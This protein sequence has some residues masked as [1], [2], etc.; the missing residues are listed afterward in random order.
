[1]VKSENLFLWPKDEGGFALFDALVDKDG[2][3][4]IFI[5]CD[6][7]SGILYPKNEEGTSTRP[8]QILDIWHARSRDGRTKWD[9]PK[10]IWKGHG[11][12]LLSVIQLHNG[13]L[14]LPFAYAVP[15]N[16]ELN[17]GGGFLDYTYVGA[18]GVSTLYSDDEGATWHQS[19]DRLVV[20]L[21]DLST[22]GA[23]EPVVLQ[24]KDG[25]VWMLMRTQLGRFYQS[26][27]NDDGEHWSPAEP[28][29]LIS[30]DSPA[31]LIRTEDGNILMF[32]NA[33]RRYPYAY[34]ARNVLHV[35]ISKDE[36]KTWRGFREVARDPLRN[37][38][39]SATGDYGLSYTFPTLLR[40]GHV[41]FSN[42]VESGR[43]R[44][45]RLLDPLW[46]N[47]T[48]Q[49]SD[50]SRG[51]ED[52]ST[53]GSKGVELEPDPEDGNVKAL[54]IR[55]AEESWPAGAVW[56]F[57]IG[58]EGQLTMRIR[59]RKGFGGTLVGLTDHF[60]VPWDLEDQFNNVFNLPITAD[61]SI[62]PTFKLSPDRWYSVIFAWDTTLRK[63]RILID[64]RSVKTVEDNR[65]SSGINYLRLRSVSEQSDTGLLIDSIKVDVSKSWP[66]GRD[67]SLN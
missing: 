49:S 38:P 46:L 20:Q 57:P 48:K 10:A 1:M 14:L 18:Y 7:N 47:E 13:R 5:L 15:R 35:A 50:F 26:F 2:E 54:S 19:P 43:D 11:S 52:W 21:P 4:H 33:C 45:F 31:G 59:L 39:P 22:Y 28:T 58:H 64:G 16:W 30:S 61:G 51:L 9:Q 53:F 67:R 44:T 36:G 40:D 42:W 3:I 34:G 24:L 37:E 65:R 66:P 6:A 62:S 60:S 56:N 29:E 27:S 12:D 17:R 23:D 63:C 41:L 55:K 8:G 32:S 25:R